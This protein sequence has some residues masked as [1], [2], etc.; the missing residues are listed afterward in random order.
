MLDLGFHLLGGALEKAAI[1]LQG[2]LV[3]AVFIQEF[4]PVIM[5]PAYLGLISRAFFQSARASSKFL[6]R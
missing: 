6:R 4:G 5:D 1:G 2:L 3:R